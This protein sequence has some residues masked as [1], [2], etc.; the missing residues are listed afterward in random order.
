M[1]FR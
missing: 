1:D